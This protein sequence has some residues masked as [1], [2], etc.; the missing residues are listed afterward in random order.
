MKTTAFSRNGYRLKTEEYEEAFTAVKAKLAPWMEQNKIKA[1]IL[2]GELMPWSLIGEGLIDRQFRSIEEGVRIELQFM[3]DHDFDG[4]FQ[5]LEQDMT[6]KGFEQP[7]DAVKDDLYKKW[8]N[9]QAKTYMLATAFLKRFR[10]IREHLDAL[11]AYSEQVRLY[12]S[13]GTPDYRPFSVLKIIYEDGREETCFGKQNDELFSLANSDECLVIDLDDPDALVK[14]Q[15]YYDKV[16][17]QGMEGIVVKPLEVTQPH[18]MVPALKVRNTEYLRIIYGYDYLFPHKYDRLLRHKSVSGKERVSAREW[19][20]GRKLLE[21]KRD[22]IS[23]KSR[24]YRH[25]VASMIAEEKKEQGLDP[26][27]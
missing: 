27:L 1:V 9:R 5:K 15:Q 13:T 12:G 26:R 14:S 18:W 24:R 8:G 21:I 10:P 6:E 25:L 17:S 23:D 2:D 11:F 4:H 22:E 19:N 7:R 20:I 16:V 3:H